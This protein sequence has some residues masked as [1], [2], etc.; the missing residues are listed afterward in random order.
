MKDREGLR[1]RV[2]P[3]RAAEGLP[4]DNGEFA[5]IEEAA[6]LPWPSEDT[7]HITWD[8]I[9]WPPRWDPTLE[10]NEETV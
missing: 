3:I 9:Q 6:D 4:F 7:S 5:L 10:T 1:E 2:H 8:D